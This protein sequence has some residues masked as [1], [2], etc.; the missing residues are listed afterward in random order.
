MAR[1]VIDGVLFEFD[2]VDLLDELCDIVNDDV[3]ICEDGTDLRSYS[4]TKSADDL[5]DR[6]IYGLN[7]LTGGFISKESLHSNGVRI[8]KNSD[9]RVS[10]VEFQN[11]FV[12]SLDTSGN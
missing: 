7:H 5:V 10:A 6:I 8:V 12:S 1:L 3:F 9:I 2:E 4:Y 11:I